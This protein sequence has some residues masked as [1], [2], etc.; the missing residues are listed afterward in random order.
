MREIVEHVEPRDALL[1]EK[2]DG[3][4]AFGLIER[5]ENVAAVHFLLPAA[6]GLQQRVF[7]HALKRHGLFGQ[8]GQLLRARQDVL[9]KK[10]FQLALE[11]LEIAAALADHVRGCAISQQRIQQMFQRHVLMPPPDR[12][13]HGR[14]E[15]LL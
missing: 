11:L 5:G 2:I 7:E 14:R 1:L 15:R 10:F 8:L 9:V 3:V 4:R 12:L 13:V 6:F